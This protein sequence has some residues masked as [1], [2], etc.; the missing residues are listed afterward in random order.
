G[1]KYPYV[2]STHTNNGV[3]CFINS[4][5]NDLHK[6]NTIT[7]NRTGSVGESFYQPYPFVASKDRIRVLIPKFKMNRYIGSFLASILRLEKYRF[8]YGRT[9]GTNRIKETKIKLPV[10]KKGNPDWKFMENYIKS[11]PYSKSLI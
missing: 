5:A 8:S 2:S 9:W 6:G 7:I 10:D 4:K 1:T 11:L 3:I